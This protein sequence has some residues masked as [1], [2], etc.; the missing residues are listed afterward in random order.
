MP[1]MESYA[2]LKLKHFTHFNLRKRLA[3]LLVLSRLDYCDSVFSPLPQYLL[4][5]LQKIEFAAASFVYGRYVNGIGDILKLNW[6][7]VHERRDFN[8][9]KLTFKALYFKQWPTYLNLQRV[10]IRR[11]LRSS[12]CI[13][14]Q[15]PLEKGTFQD[16]AALLFNNLPK[17][18]KTCDDVNIFTSRLFKYLRNRAKTCLQ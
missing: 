9:L 2:H 6:L 17:E 8:L 13:R 1:L 5:R 16:T 11:E 10:S 18:L 12:D 3:E 4:K 15:V 7:P 14:L